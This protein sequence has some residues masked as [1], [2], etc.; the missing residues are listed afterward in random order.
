MI[1]VNIYIYDI[2]HNRCNALQRL[3]KPSLSSPS[4]PIKAKPLDPHLKK[5]GASKKHLFM[6]LEVIRQ[7]SAQILLTL[8]CF[9]RAGLFYG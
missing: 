1:S 7:F 4:P 9:H 2:N 3:R 6:S 8:K 5:Y